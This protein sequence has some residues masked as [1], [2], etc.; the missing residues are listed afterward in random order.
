MKILFVQHLGFINGTG[1]TEK[2]CAFLANHFCSLGYDVEIA[3]NENIQGKEIYPLDKRIKLSNIY[4]SNIKQVKLLPLFNYNGK[5]IFSWLKYKFTKKRA[6]F[7]NKKLLKEIG[8]EDGIY[9][10]NLRNRAKAW[11]HFIE[12]SSKPDLIITMSIGS[13]LEIS[14][15]NELNVPIINSTNGRP[16]YDYS[17][18]L[19]YRN[20]AEMLQLKKCYEKLTS[21]QILFEEYK[22]FLP[23]TFQGKTYIIGNPIP[24]AKENEIIN[25]LTPKESYTIIHIGSLNTSCK[26]QD[27]AIHVFEKLAEKHPHWNLNFWG[28]GDDKKYLE[29]LIQQKNLK[30]RV[31]IN[32]FTD[33]PLEELKKS[34]I[35][36]FPSKYEGFPL[37]LGEAMSVGLPC[38]GLASCSGVNQMIINGENGFL[39]NDENDIEKHLET[40]I[41]NQELRQKMGLKAHQMMKNFTPKEITQQWEKLVQETLKF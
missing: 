15:E 40:L 41:Q 17:N 4:S 37:A 27:V 10:F 18:I 22:S 11:K 29:N 16:D 21:I 6:K 36:I 12:N 35:F 1:G 8:G 7:F 31:F 2:I 13:L 39:A 38:I 30:N 9:I 20:P 25:H 26:Q 28:L 14:F 19:W 23:K 32:G 5:N 24:Q 3:T 33:T 34:D